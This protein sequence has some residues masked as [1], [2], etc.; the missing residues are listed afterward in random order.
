MSVCYIFSCSFA[1]N[2][3]C[4]GPNVCPFLCR[5]KSGNNQTDLDLYNAYE[6]KE[7]SHETYYM[8]F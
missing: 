1:H 4:V 8:Q 7:W 6:K 2:V 5:I 3:F